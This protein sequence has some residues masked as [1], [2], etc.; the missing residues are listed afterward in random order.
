MNLSCSIHERR[1]WL[2]SRGHN[3]WSYHDH[4]HTQ[5]IQTHSSQTSSNGGS[6][7]QRRNKES[8]AVNGDCVASRP[9][10]HSTSHHFP[11]EINRAKERARAFLR[12]ASSKRVCSI[13]TSTLGA[14]PL[15]LS[16]F[17]TQV[18]PIAIEA[19]LRVHCSPRR[20]TLSGP[21][22]Y[23]TFLSAERQTQSLRKGKPPGFCSKVSCAEKFQV[24]LSRCPMDSNRSPS[25]CLSNV[26][27]HTFAFL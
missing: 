6:L 14:K 26:Q 3:G 17:I 12:H 24:S 4:D 27:P 21:T 15:N 13:P 22:W 10:T 19:N 2:T 1:K 5:K 18:A 7:A 11:I 16:R 8:R 25:H 23:R 20:E 9:T